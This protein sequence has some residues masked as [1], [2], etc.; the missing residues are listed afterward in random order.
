[1]SNP[2]VIVLGLDGLESSL[3][4]RWAAEGEL[5]AMRE[6]LETGRTGVGASPAGLGNDATWSSFNSGVNPGRTG[7]YFVRQV[8]PGSYRSDY[9]TADDVHA[10]P[11][12]NWI[13]QAGR[14][15]AA[16]D[17]PYAAVT[18]LNG[19]AVAD[20]L[21]H[22]PLYDHV[23]QT[24]PPDLART[25]LTS[26]GADPVGRSDRP[27]KRSP[28]QLQ[29]LADGLI[30]KTRLKSKFVESLL[31]NDSWDLMCVAY[32]DG[33]CAGHQFWH[34]HD[35][36]YRDYDAAAAAQVGDLM[37]AVY[38]EIDTAVGELLSRTTPSTTVM[39]FTGPGMGPN[40]T[41]SH[42]LDDVLR[43]L[44]P[45]VAPPRRRIM[46]P[47][48]AGYRSA[49]PHRVRSRLR[50]RAD[51]ID[52]ASQ[53]AMR[54]K[55]RFYAVPSNEIAGA[56]RLNLIGRDPY[57]TVAPGADRDRLTDELRHEL[58]EL[59]NI[60]TGHPVVTDVVR[61]DALYH[62]EYVDWLPDLLVLWTQLEPV[63]GVRSPRI[64]D[65]WRP[66]PGQRTGDH[67]AEFLFAARGPGIAPG[68]MENLDVASFAPT[69]S[70]MLDVAPPE[71][72]DGATNA[73][74]LTR[75]TQP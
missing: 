27:G 56:V 49:V 9:L 46:D 30:S 62:G 51:G 67:T 59:R 69:V 6:L 2:E 35:P 66:Y 47:L 45:D 44:E 50:K 65:V 12:W 57:G 60:E 29:D 8:R 1:M 32:T 10:E 33:H 73:D 43:R 5:P 71:G 24:S 28:R 17:M 55:R 52:E 18:P 39:A 7:R 37:L 11:F 40:H 15:V 58:L 4:R 31:Q 16:V 14:R 72:L 34:V 22:G 21:V 74:L 75:S 19:V 42:I 64:G 68:T 70:E 26:F 53:V 23:I 54:R 38:K 3:L 48:R 63:I 61:S 25:I 41:A 13:S 36:T 20:W